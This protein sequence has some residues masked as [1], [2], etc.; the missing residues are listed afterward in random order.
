[1]PIIQ[2]KKGIRLDKR[3]AKALDL[4]RSQARKLI[5]SGQIVI[6]QQICRDVGLNTQPNQLVKY[7]DKSLKVPQKCYIMLHKPTG[8]LSTQAQAN[9]P[10]ALTLLQGVSS[11]ELHFAGRLDIDTTGLLLISNDGQWS[12]RVTAPAK[13]Q[14][15]CYRVVLAD[16]ISSTQK[17]QIEHGIRL[18]DSDKL[19]RPTK[20]EVVAAKLIGSI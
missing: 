4:P 11:S 7:G 18:K 1:M 14:A 2:S 10:S 3:V 19:T 8:Y 12:H 6:D 15:K 5:K 17:Q 9:H 16:N 20:V 13:K